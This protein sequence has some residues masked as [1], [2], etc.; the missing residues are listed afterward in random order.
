MGTR[1][2]HST[3]EKNAAPK[4]ERM[5]DY[6]HYSSNTGQAKPTGAFVAAAATIGVIAAG[7]ALLEVTLIPGMAIGAAAV[8]APKYVRK[9]RR[10]RP[11][12]SNSIVRQRADPAVD[13]PDRPEVMAALAAP[14]GFAIKQ[15]IA[16]TITF[17]ITVTTVDFT[18]HFVV[19]GNIATAASLSASHLILRPLFYL[20]HETA[21]NY[22]SPPVRRRAGLKNNRALGPS[23]IR[24]LPRPWTSL[25]TTLWL[26]TSAPR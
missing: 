18:T 14:A 13:P 2:E 25:L 24:P 17:Q 22:L 15:A 21:W 26:A 20:M 4:V 1:C 9:L 23:L 3:A 16:K 19:I 12:P 6:N 10:H 11:L 8:L 5:R 7:V